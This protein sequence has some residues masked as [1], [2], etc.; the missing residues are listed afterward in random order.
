M[1]TKEHKQYLKEF[2]AFSR[3]IISSR[4]SALDFL[5]RSGIV[6]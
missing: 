4:E 6:L 1:T 5:I 2:K 3:E